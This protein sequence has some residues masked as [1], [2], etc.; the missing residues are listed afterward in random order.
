[1]LTVAI[2]G[3]GE[4]SRLHHGAALHALRN[5]LGRL[6]VT[7]LNRNAAEA[8]QRDY[9]LDRAYDRM[10]TMLDAEQPDAVIAVTPV[11]VTGKVFRELVKY[12]IPLLMEKPFGANAVE[13]RSLHELAVQSQTKLMVSFNRRFSPVITRMRE[14][15]RGRSVE[16]LAGTMARTHRHDKDFIHTTA[17]HLFDILN[18]FAGDVAPQSVEAGALLQN[19]SALFH[20]PGGITASV[21]IH[22]DCGR[23]AECYDIIGDGFYIEADYFSGCRLYEDGRV[24][25]EYRIP[26]DSPLAFREGAVA[27]LEHF[28]DQIESHQPHFASTSANA[29]HAAMAAEQIP[30]MVN[31]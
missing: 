30:E 20:Y 16:H 18:Y 29:L 3:A 15:L 31:S 8:F 9:E 14:M 27:E 5:R 28:I 10:E 19:R 21:A 6:S 26:P 4:H 7:D 12:H 24:V 11:N 25:D 13:S 1:M 22:P 23:L 17:I 2:I